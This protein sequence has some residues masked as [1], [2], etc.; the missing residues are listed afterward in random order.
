M[1]EVLLGGV[2]D[3]REWLPLIAALKRRLPGAATAE[4]I[5]FLRG[6]ITALKGVPGGI[7]PIILSFE[8]DA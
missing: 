6:V 3:E 5:S 1:I 7:M 2:S 8:A 4:Q